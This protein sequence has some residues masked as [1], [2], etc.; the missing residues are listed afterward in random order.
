MKFTLTREQLLTPLQ[1]VAGVVERRQT[2]PILSNVLLKL[3]KTELLLTGTDLEVQQQGRVELDADAVTEVGEITVPARKLMD[4]CRTLT[5]KSQLEITL[6]H[7]KLIIRSGRSRFTLNTLPADEFP[8]MEELP[9]EMEFSLDQ[10]QLRALIEQTQFAMAQQDIRHYLNGMLWEI[11]KNSLSMAATDGHRLAFGTLN[12]S[13]DG[14]TQIIVPRKGM[15]E[16]SRILNDTEQKIDVFAGTNQLRVR[17]HDCIFTT[18]LIDGRYPDYRKVIPKS[19]DKILIVDRDLLKQA[20]NRV[21]VLSNEKFRGIRLELR[22]DLLRMV[23]HNPEQEEAEEEL[24]VN[25]RMADLDMGFNVTYLLEAISSLPTGN[26]R[27]T[28]ADESN[29]LKIE[30]ESGHDRIYVVMPMQL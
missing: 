29:A 11:K 5:E 19:G 17:T 26:V 28:F 23:S 20:L 18:K 3:K 8:C 9:G 15:L 21:A 30:A 6:D 14:D 24:G 27:F 4:I 22:N 2:L 7:P 1:W 16:L 25:Y 12:C 10:Q 13:V